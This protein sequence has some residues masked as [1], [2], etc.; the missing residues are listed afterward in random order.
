MDRGLRAQMYFARG[1]QRNDP[2]A[3]QGFS[4]IEAGV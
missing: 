3:H 2:P 1:R 4:G